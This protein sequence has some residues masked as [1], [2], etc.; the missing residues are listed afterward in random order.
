MWRFPCTRLCRAWSG[1]TAERF[2]CT[3][4]PKTG[5]GTLLRVCAC[6]QAR[7]SDHR[8]QTR[9][10][11]AMQSGKPTVLSVYSVADG[12]TFSFSATRVI[13]ESISHGDEP[14]VVIQ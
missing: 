8:Q 7:H 6:A 2:L 4:R 3:S 1:V 12:G 10:Q 5:R 9:S 13:I 14:L 11:T